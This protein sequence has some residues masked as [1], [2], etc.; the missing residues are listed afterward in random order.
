M[1][2]S[3]GESPDDREGSR[4]RAQA[5]GERGEYGDR[6]AAGD[7]DRCIDMD[8]AGDHRAVATCTA[9]TPAYKSVTADAGRI[10]TG[11]ESNTPG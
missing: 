2:S 1:V 5:R 7:G 3:G 6:R 4:R 8:V 9:S 10:A 11:D